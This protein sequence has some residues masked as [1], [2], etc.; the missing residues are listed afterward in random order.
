[1]LAAL[2]EFSDFKKN[3]RNWDGKM[4]VG[5]IGRV[6]GG[7]EVDFVKAHCMYV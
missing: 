4:M 2:N 3:T 5:A 1:M 6:I 7:V